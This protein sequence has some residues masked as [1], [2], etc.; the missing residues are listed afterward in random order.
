MGLKS[1]AARDVDKGGPQ[2]FTG[3]SHTTASDITVQN[4]GRDMIN[5]PS[6]S[7]AG[8]SNDNERLMALVGSLLGGGGCGR[9]RDA[10]QSSRY[11]P[12]QTPPRRPAPDSS[13]TTPKSPAIDEGCE[14]EE[15]LRSFF[16]S[17][18]IDF[19]DQLSLLVAED[20][21]PEIIPSVDASWL[22]NDFL[23]TTIGKVIRL[24]KHAKIW[25]ARNKKKKVPAK[26]TRA[27]SSPVS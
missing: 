23:H 1:Q 9:R 26:H 22:A 24:Q 16:S 11:H 5:G 10:G 12:Y 17:T 21:T 6:R 3:A 13:D 15:F 25:D 19:R 8:S 20:I 2:F 4:A 7:G 14:L 18:G 27:S